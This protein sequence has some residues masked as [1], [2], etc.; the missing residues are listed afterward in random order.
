[1]PH[2]AP[3]NSHGDVLKYI[4]TTYPASAFQIHTAYTMSELENMLEGV[5]RWPGVASKPQ[6]D[7]VTRSRP[8]TTAIAQ[9]KRSEYIPT[10]QTTSIFSKGSLLSQKVAA[11]QPQPVS[12]KAPQKTVVAATKNKEQQDGQQSVISL[13]KAMRE[14]R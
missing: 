11:A 5:S 9:P 13:L 3:A 8:V 1:M 2:N 12:F 14:G 10:N 4:S 7:S 6:K